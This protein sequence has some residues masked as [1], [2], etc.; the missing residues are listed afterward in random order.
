MSIDP[1]IAARRSEVREVEARADARRSL[2]WLGA[3]VVVGL[4]AWVAQGPIFSIRYLEVV[5]VERSD[6]IVALAGGGITEGRPMLLMRSDVALELLRSDPWVVD[7]H[8]DV[9]YP[10]RVTVQVVERRPAL[11]VR[12]DAG[13]FVVGHDGVVVARSTDVDGSLPFADVPA[14]GPGRVGFPADA[15]SAGLTEFVTGLPVGLARAGAAEV[16]DGEVWFLLPDLAV[17]LGR[18]VEM[19]AKAAVLAALVEEGVEPGSVVHLVTPRRPAVE[20]PS[21]GSDPT[22]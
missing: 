9:A 5:G 21:P 6:P 16:R 7:A 12:S 2:W 15:A 11:L 14:A 20:P 8:I 18:P 1:R 3:L 22:D 4:A 17:R 10:D 13:G 19:A